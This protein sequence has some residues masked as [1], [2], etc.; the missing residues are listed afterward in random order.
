MRQLQNDNLKEIL[1]TLGILKFG[2]FLFRFNSKSCD[3]KLIQSSYCQEGRAAY[4]LVF[5]F[6][7]F[8]YYFNPWAFPQPL[9][10]FNGI[11]NTLDLQLTISINFQCQITCA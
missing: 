1:G 5:E 3:T 10:S 2:L 11:L 9:Y 6:L 7:H 4:D 8:S